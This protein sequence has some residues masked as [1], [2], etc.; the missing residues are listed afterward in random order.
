MRPKIFAKL[1]RMYYLWV[2]VRL[3]FVEMFSNLANVVKYT[4]NLNDPK[5]VLP[6]AF[7]NVECVF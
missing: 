5:N 7:R 3:T 6:H 2:S 4:Y 1:W